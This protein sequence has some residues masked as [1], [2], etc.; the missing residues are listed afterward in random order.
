MTKIKQSVLVDCPLH[1][2]M[3]YAERYFSVHRKGQEQGTF[4]LTVDSAALNMPGRVQASHQ[5]NVAYEVK[6]AAGNEADAISL[7]WDPQD[8]MMP[9]FAGV[10]HAE[11]SEG[12]HSTLILEGTYNP[13]FGAVGAAFDAVLGQRIASATANSLLEDIKTFIEESYGVAR[14]TTLADSPKE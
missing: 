9:R 5:V 13:P 8:K 11:R 4:T 14:K 6:K 10:L 7:A 1:E 3:Y 2:I 12:A